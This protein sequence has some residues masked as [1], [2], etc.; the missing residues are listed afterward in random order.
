MGG[1]QPI[2]YRSLIPYY[3]D[4]SLINSTLAFSDGNTA[5]L[6]D[7]YPNI[8]GNNYSGSEGASGAV[9]N[10]LIKH[11]DGKEGNLFAAFTNNGGYK[12]E[13]DIDNTRYVVHAPSGASVNITNEVKPLGDTENID[14]DNSIKKAFSE[15]VNGM[16]VD[17][18]FDYDMKIL[19]PVTDTTY[20]DIVREASGET[21][22]RQ[23][24][25]TRVYGTIY[26]GIEMSYDNEYNI[27][28]SYTVMQKVEEI[29]PE[30]TERISA[31]SIYNSDDEEIISAFTTV[32]G[33]GYTKD[34]ERSED[35][36]LIYT[37]D[38]DA[39]GDLYIIKNYYLGEDS[40]YSAT[41]Q[42]YCV[43]INKFS[44]D[45]IYDKDNKPMEIDEITS[46]KTEIRVGNVVVG[47]EYEWN[48]IGGN[49]TL[50][51]VDNKYHYIWTEDE[52]GESKPNYY[53]EYSYDTRSTNGASGVT[54]YTHADTGR[55]YV[56]E[57]FDNDTSDYMCSMV[58]GTTDTTIYKVSD[59]TKATRVPTY[60]KSNIRDIDTRLM[61]WSKQNEFSLGTYCKS[62]GNRWDGDSKFYIFNHSGETKDN[63]PLYNGIFGK[64]NYPTKRYFDIAV[65]N[66]SSSFSMKT[67]SC[68][69]EG[70]IFF[71]EDNLIRTN[72]NE[73][74]TWE[75]NLKFGKVAKTSGTV[76]YNSGGT[77][78]GITLD[79]LY[80]N[81]TNAE[82]AIY[83]SRP[84]LITPNDIIAAKSA[85]T[86]DINSKLITGN[87]TVQVKSMMDKE[88]HKADIADY[89]DESGFIKYD[90][91]FISND[92]YEFKE[93][94]AK[95]STSLSDVNLIAL[96]VKRFYE[97]YSSDNL[98]KKLITY[99]FCDFYN[100]AS[101]DTGTYTYR[102][103]SRQPI[104]TVSF[105]HE[106][107]FIKEGVTAELYVKIE[108]SYGLGQKGE[109]EQSKTIVLEKD[110]Q[111]GSF[112]LEIELGI[113]YYVSRVLNI[114]VGVKKNGFE[115]KLHPRKV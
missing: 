64:G 62:S 87:C 63:V 80:S 14:D 54:K 28:S 71:N 82:Y 60:Y 92:D 84:Y 22:S 110:K 57:S 44:E 58:S 72:M 86:L 66:P 30:T 52:F 107:F 13:Y 75:N 42:P 103:E 69:H 96:V 7:M 109:H 20:I 36:K 106:T 25:C 49:R 45:I 12:N 46:A 18:R 104:F 94:K 105:E 108:Y 16:F 41:P 99:E 59:I 33:S 32:A 61:Y 24:A 51:E 4:D 74:W 6:N 97:P 113:N 81:F 111:D 50:Y 26:N 48:S 77:V 53:L 95:I 2:L 5:A 29:K 21:A 102:Y 79:L 23:F 70:G 76:E 19:A 39:S 78:S 85:L 9:F 3:K 27:I 56:W 34:D 37:K 17:R 38:N 31:T 68:S 11:V 55:T 89:R 90:D 1:V 40:S 114:Y 88:Y 65:L 8:I 112:K 101:A 43:K 91:D 93:M 73:G 47:Y 35:G 100:F 115:Y 67:T 15:Y 83:S 10:P 98:K